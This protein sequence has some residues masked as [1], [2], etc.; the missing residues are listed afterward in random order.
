MMIDDNDAPK[1]A[2]IVPAVGRSVNMK[3]LARSRAGR[4]ISLSG[5]PSHAPRAIMPREK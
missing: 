5:L 2:G 3:N 4:L 1:L